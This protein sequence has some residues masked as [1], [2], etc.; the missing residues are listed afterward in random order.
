MKV[1]ITD[2]KN[3][4]RVICRFQFLSCNGSE[5]LSSVTCVG[6]VLDVVYYASRSIEID[7]SPASQIQIVQS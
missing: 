5:M 6:G 1:S 2:E 4:R 3:V 7:T